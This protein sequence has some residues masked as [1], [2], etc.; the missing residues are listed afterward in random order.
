MND[1]YRHSLNCGKIHRQIVEVKNAD[2][3]KRQRTKRQIGQKV[4]EKNVERTKL[5]MVDNDEST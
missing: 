1:Q 5:R 3:K 2:G 4:D